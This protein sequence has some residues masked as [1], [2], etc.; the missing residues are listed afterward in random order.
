M[1]HAAFLIVFAFAAGLGF[2]QT[3]SLKVNQ[4]VFDAQGHLVAYIYADGTKDR[5]TYDGAWRM[6]SFRDRTGK[7]TQFPYANADN[8]AGSQA[9]T[10]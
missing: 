2:A 6:T 5:Y 1:K 7:L 3:G 10:K 4:P 9:K 8:S